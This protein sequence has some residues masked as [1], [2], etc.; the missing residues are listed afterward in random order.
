MIGESECPQSM[1][2]DEEEVMEGGM[3]TIGS[4]KKGEIRR[5]EARGMIDGGEIMST[6]IMTAMAGIET[7]VT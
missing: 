1:K 7:G 6:G 2:I 5:S 4:D 3:R